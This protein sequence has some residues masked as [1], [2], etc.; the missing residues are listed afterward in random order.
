ML[1]WGSNEQMYFEEF[2]N[3]KAVLIFFF[4]LKAVFIV[5]YWVIT[6]SLGMNLSKLWEIVEIGK[7]GV[8]QSMGLQRVRPNLATEQ[9]WVSVVCVYSSCPCRLWRT[10]SFFSAASRTRPFPW[11]VLLTFML[12][13]RK[14]EGKG[15]PFILIRL[16]NCGFEE[17]SNFPKIM[18]P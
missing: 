12:L 8:L 5:S 2:V 17:G 6:D 11:V 7:P 3:H 9:Q 18:S 14:K 1:L 4:F 13:L 15:H 16:E 10:D